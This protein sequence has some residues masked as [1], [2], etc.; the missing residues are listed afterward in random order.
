MKVFAGLVVAASATVDRIRTENWWPANLNAPHCGCQLIIDPA[1]HGGY[2]NS[3]CTLKFPYADQANYGRVA[4]GDPHFVSVA[5]S[6]MV[7][8]D[9]TVG[10]DGFKFTGFD[11]V[12]NPDVLDILVFYEHADCARGGSI[13]GRSI[14][15]IPDLEQ[16]QIWEVYNVTEAQ[17]PAMC[18]YVL[19]CE[20]NGKP[21]EGVFLG[22]FNY[23][24]ARSVQT[25]TV[26]VYGL[27]QGEI[28]TF[29]IKD[30]YG[31]PANCM[32]AESHHGHGFVD[33]K[34]S[35][36]DNTTCGNTIIYKQNEDHNGLLEYFQFEPVSP[37][38]NPF[39]WAQPLHH[40]DD[41][42][43]QTPSPWDTQQDFIRTQP[44]DED[45]EE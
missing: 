44:E 29:N 32:N 4:A 35:C 20:D 43:W 3:T 37:T 30:Y 7:G 45:E 17:G 21:L 28:A 31:E 6:Y 9:R 16:S 33:D 27:E 39:C 1:D 13:D 10:P 14:D 24:I 12:S 26:P 15:E 22:N 23:D 38:N 8:R 11:E 25:Y 36:S 2:I 34:S 40:V 5:S 19:D 42:Q 18:E 41:Y